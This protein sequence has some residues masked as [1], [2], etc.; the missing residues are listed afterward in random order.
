MPG[1]REPIRGWI[2]SIYCFR[3]A[4]RKGNVNV[5]LAVEGIPANPV[6]ITIQ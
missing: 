3:L 1:P 6:Q 5:Q 4:G 2:R